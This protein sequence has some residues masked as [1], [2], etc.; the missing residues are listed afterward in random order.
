MTTKEKAVFEEKIEVGLYEA[1]FWRK[2]E[3]KVQTIALDYDSAEDEIDEP[4]DF[5]FDTGDEDSDIDLQFSIFKILVTSSFPFTD[6]LS[7][8]LRDEIASFA[9]E[10][11]NLLLDLH[12]KQRKE[13]SLRRIRRA[14]NE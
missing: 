10:N 6:N 13:E 5:E 11:K 8:S 7:R 12:R 1:T 2:Q 3:A 14:N 4:S 9:K